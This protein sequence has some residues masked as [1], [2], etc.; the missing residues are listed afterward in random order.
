MK[1]L[2]KTYREIEDAKTG[3]ASRLRAI[4]WRDA[5][6]NALIVPGV[7]AKELLQT[8]KKSLQEFW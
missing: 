7:L 8:I 3:L 2:I 6:L 1:G 5:R 4:S